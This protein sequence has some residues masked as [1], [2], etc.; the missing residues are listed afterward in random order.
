MTRVT[1][2]RSRTSSPFFF[3]QIP[4]SLIWPLLEEGRRS[5]HCQGTRV[6]DP[7]GRCLLDR[8]SFGRRLC[9]LSLRKEAVRPQ[10]PLV[11]ARIPLSD[12]G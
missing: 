7:G 1:S 8:V 3:Y 11:P 5:G 10:Q 2:P 6:R 4:N 12:L 9:S